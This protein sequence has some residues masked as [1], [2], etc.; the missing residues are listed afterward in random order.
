[1]TMMDVVRIDESTR[2]L[3]VRAAHNTVKANGEELRKIG[4]LIDAGKVKP[5]ISKVF[6][7]ARSTQRSTMSRKVTPKARSCSQSQPEIGRA[8]T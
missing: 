5:K 2:E 3:G 4:R 8:F 1:M 6:D 7:S